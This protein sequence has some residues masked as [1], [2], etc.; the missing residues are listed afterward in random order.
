MIAEG[1]AA[2]DFEGATEDGRRVSLSDFRGRQALVLYFYPKDATPGCT[3]EACSFR[4][5]RAEIESLGAAVV[6]VS[7]DSAE[8]H[9][10]FSAAQRLNFPLL[11][12]TDGRIASE[13][14]VTRL[15]GWLPF[16][17]VKRVTF[18]IDRSGVVRK[19]IQSELSMDAH[20]DGAIEAL[21]GLG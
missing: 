6:G 19:V 20:V 18:V 21:R 1:Q 10:K 5:H 14:G 4:D 15:G 9:R 2:P 8:S 12:D 13:Y 3:K 7:M 17:P 16:L 11:A